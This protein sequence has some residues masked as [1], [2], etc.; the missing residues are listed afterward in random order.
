MTKLLSMTTLLSDALKSSYIKGSRDV[1]TSYILHGLRIG[2][3][4]VMI[5]RNFQTACW[6]PPVGSRGSHSIYLGDMMLDRVIDFFVKKNTSLGKLPIFSRDPSVGFGDKI[7][8]IK[9]NL[10]EEQWGELEEQLV[11]AVAAYGRHEREHARNT[12]RD[13]KAINQRLRKEGIQFSWFN[14]FEDARIESI[15]R[16][17]QSEKFNWMKLED[18]APQDSPFA[19]Y[20]RCIQLEEEPDAEA[21]ANVD[22]LKG[23]ERTIAEAAKLVQGFYKRTIA[24]KTDLEMIPIIKEFL[25][26]FQEENE[27]Q[28][29]GSGSSSG[30]GAG[31]RAEDLSPA[32]QAAELGDEFLE[33]F[34][35]DCEI[36]D[37]NDEEAQEAAEQAK[38]GKSSESKNDKLMGDRKDPFNGDFTKVEPQESAGRGS[39]EDFL[40][41]TPYELSEE[42]LSRVDKIVQELSRLFKTNT[43]NMALE[44]PGRR[45]SARHLARNEL[46][47]LHKRSFGG[48]GKRKYTIVFDSSGSMSGEPAHEGRL[49]LMALNRIARQGHLEGDLILSGYVA[50][51]PSWLKYSFPLQEGL[52]MSIDPKLG[53]EGL[54]PALEDNLKSLKLMDDV[55]VFTDACICDDPIDRRMFARNRVHPVGLYASPHFEEARNVDH[56]EEHFPQNILRDS[57][58]EVVKQ[59][60]IRNRR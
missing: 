41:H 51:R 21:L 10:S 40:A 38:E 16:K 59:M 3:H 20:L 23:S 48:K 60:L 9:E 56:M 53:A 35:Q 4:R 32:Q 33:E 44:T 36:I 25:E 52:I 14:L 34:E 2:T 31:D 1:A 13:L 55:F 47:F 7:N 58:E 28:G 50:G 45:M 19:L 37:G 18:I 43:L 57:I 6:I 49:F 42:D 24:C 12:S 15:S 39:P 30:S 26:E 22:T 5:K 27:Q 29:D 54:Q 46:R 8:Y 17:E 11:L